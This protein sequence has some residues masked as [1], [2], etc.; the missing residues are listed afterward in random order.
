MGSLRHHFD[1]Y[2]CAEH[3]T[4]CMHAWLLSFWKCAR[5]C[6]LPWLATGVCG[7]NDQQAN[8]RLHKNMLNRSL[9]IGG[10]DGLVTQHACH[11][12]CLISLCLGSYQAL[13]PKRH[14][15]VKLLPNHH[16][17]NICLV[18]RQQAA[19][20]PASA[21]CIQS[22]TRSCIKEAIH[23]LINQAGRQAGKQAGK[24]AAFHPEKMMQGSASHVSH[25]SSCLQSSP[26][27][28]GLSVGHLGGQEQLW[29]F[30]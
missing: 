5:C 17:C 16:T 3:S 6:S 14:L 19:H 1:A 2:P 11:R 13:R 26:I 12:I 28:S 24:Q 22:V 18:R 7:Q 29:L 8:R 21:I 15:A 27:G 4:Q 23:A 10:S 9:L 30:Q 20:A 25:E